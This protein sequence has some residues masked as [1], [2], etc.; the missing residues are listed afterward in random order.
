MIKHPKRRGEWVE[1]QFMSRAAH[2]GLTV[3]KPWGDS[4]RYDFIVEHKGRCVRVQ[5]KS[6]Y[7]YRRGGYQCK[8][9]TGS[10]VYS[11]KD[12]EFVVAFIIPEEIWYVIPIGEVEGY[13]GVTLEPRRTTNKYFRYMEAWHLLRNRT[14]QTMP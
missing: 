4:A 5:V 12:I 7:F 8:F 10:G 13:L 9:L 1:L 3:S 14:A 11:K 6:T 2:H